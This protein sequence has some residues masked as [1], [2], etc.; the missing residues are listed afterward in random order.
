MAAKV[1]IPREANLTPA[2]QGV[3]DAATPGERRRMQKH[4]R[5]LSTIEF[6]HD[7]AGELA[8]AL[9]ELH[10]VS[11]EH[12]VPVAEQVRKLAKLIDTAMNR[13]KE[14]GDAQEEA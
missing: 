4:M 12:R 8:A 13:D 5:W 3:Y 1:L 10:L 11:R 6:P 7:E 14:A 2:E 9:N